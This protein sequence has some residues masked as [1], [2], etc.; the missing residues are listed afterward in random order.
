VRRGSRRR[1]SKHLLQQDLVV[2][3]DDDEVRSI[4]QHTSAYVSIRQH[5]SANV[6]IR[7]HLLQQGLVVADN[8]Q[9]PL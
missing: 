2:V 4:R 6:S 7:R 9:V 3:P 5:T 1:Y 8:V